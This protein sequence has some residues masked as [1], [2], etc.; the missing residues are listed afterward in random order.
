M[1]VNSIG[2]NTYQ[3]LN[4]KQQ[5][6]RRPVENTQNKQ[7]GKIGKIN[8]PVQKDKVGSDLAV[9]LPGENYMEMLTAE[10][11]EAFEMV[12]KKFNGAG[13]APGQNGLG[14]FIDVKL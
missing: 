10:E 9:K 6:A 11:K 4:D 3:Q 8:I 1:K 5:I 13:G 12:F 7:A 2:I 14:R